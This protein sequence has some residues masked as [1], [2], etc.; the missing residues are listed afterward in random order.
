[1]CLKLPLLVLVALALPLVGYCQWN[2]QTS[3]T[4]FTINDIHYINE[5][6]GFLGTNSAIYKTMDRGASW[7]S[8]TYPAGIDGQILRNAY[9]NDILFLDQTNGLMTGG[10]YYGTYDMV[11]KTSDGGNSWQ[12]VYS[13]PMTGT[14][15]PPLM[16][17][18]FVDSNV[19]FIAGGG[20]K[21][22]K[23]Y[24]KGQTW[25]QIAS[26]TTKDLE[27]VFFVD[28]QNGFIAGNKVLLK[29]T[30]GGTSW[31]ATSLLAFH[32]K[33]L[34]FFTS[35]T[36]VAST[37][38]G[39]IL[40]TADGG[41]TWT[42]HPLNFEKSLTKM[43]FQGLTGYVGVFNGENKKLILKTTDGGETWE[44]QLIN[45]TY[46]NPMVLAMTP[47]GT[48]W[49]GG[50]YGKLFS[51][52]NGGGP[53][54]PIAAFTTSSNVFCQNIS[55]TFINKGSDKYTYEWRVD[56][57]VKST[58]HNF[59]TSFSPGNHTVELKAI[60]G[61]FSDKSEIS[62]FTEY[63]VGFSAPPE[64]VFD[65]G[66]CQG[67]ST[68]IVVKN[69][70]WA[71][72]KLMQGNV[73]L[74]TDEYPE[75]RFQTPLLQTTTTFKVVVSRSNSCETAT[76]ES[77]A[78]ITVHEDL[79]AGSN[80][81]AVQKYFCNEGQA[82]IKVTA[83]KAG[84]NYSLY[85]N[86]TLVN[87]TSG[88]GDNIVLQG[89]VIRD[90]TQFTVKA[91]VA[92]GVCTREFG[93]LIQVDVEQVKADFSLSATNAALN[94]PVNIYNLSSGATNF[95]W[96]F[97]GATTPSFTGASPSP[98]SFTHTGTLQPVLHASSNSGCTDVVT[99]NIHV[100]DNTLLKQSCWATGI[101]LTAERDGHGYEFF[102]NSSAIAPNGDILITGSFSGIAEFDSKVGPDLV[103]PNQ[104][105][106]TNFLARYSPTGVL[107]W[108]F[109]TSRYEI[110]NSASPVG[111][112]VAV[113]DDGSIYLLTSYGSFNPTFYSANGVATNPYEG[114]FV[115]S[116]NQHYLIKYSP[117]GML[118][119]IRSEKQITGETSADMFIDM[120]LDAS[121][122]IFIV[123]DHVYKISSSGDVLM[124]VKVFDSPVHNQ[125]A[126]FALSPDG[127]WYCINKRTTPILIRRYSSTGNAEWE[128]TISTVSYYGVVADRQNNLI[129]T[130][131]AYGA[132]NSRFTSNGEADRVLDPRSFFMVKYS[133]LGKISWLN[134]ALTNAAFRPGDLSADESGNISFTTAVA[135]TGQGMLQSQDG[136]H[137]NFSVPS[138]PYLISYDQNGSITY[139]K[140]IFEDVVA[141]YITKVTSKAGRSIVIG[142]VFSSEM[143]VSINN[144]ALYSAYP[145]TLFLAAFDISCAA[146]S[147]NVLSGSLEDPNVLFCAGSTVKLN[148]EVSA[149]TQLQPGNVIKVLLSNSDGNFNYGVRTIGTLTSIASQGIIQALLPGD[150]ASGNNY[151]LKLWATNPQLIS[152][153]LPYQLSIKSSLNLDFTYSSTADLVLNFKSSTTEVIDAR[154]TIEGNTIQELSPTYKF[155]TTGLFNVCLKAKN[156]C[157]VEETVCHD[158]VV[159]CAP[160][161]TDFTYSVTG[162]T[163]TFTG[164][165]NPSNALHW[166]FGD[167]AT[168]TNLNVQHTYSTY[169]EKG[170]CLRS[171]TECNQ[172]IACKS[173]TLTCSQGP[174]SFGSSSVDR[175]VQFSNTSPSTYTAF[176]WDFG[177]GTSS[178]DKNPTHLYD[179]PGTYTVILS[180]QGECRLQTLAKSVT[181]TCTSPTASPAGNAVQT[182]CPGATVANLSAIGTSVKWYATPTGGA[183]LSS[184][185]PLTN[186][187][188]YYASQTIGGCQST[189]RLDVN[190]SI[191]NT[192]SPAGNAVQTFC[193][194]ATVANLSVT[195]TS[196]KWYATPTGG[197]VLSLS[198]PLTNSKHY[199]ASQTI[200]G[201]ESTSRLDVNVSITNTASPAGNAVQTF[202]AGATVANLSAT[203]T[204]VKWYATPTGGA[205]L[206]S[207]TP[208]T[209]GTHYYASQTIGSCESSVRLD[210]S[211]SLTTTDP[212][213][214]NSTQTFC[215][216]ATISNLVVNG[217]FIKWYSALVGGSAL[218]SSTP[219]TNN[220]YYASQTINGCESLVR[221]KITAVENCPIDKTA[222]TIISTF[223]VNRTAD[224]DPSS[225]LTIHFSEP[226]VLGIPSKLRVRYFVN[227]FN[228]FQDITLSNSNTS[229]EGEIVTIQ[230]ETNLPDG[231]TVSILIDAG[232]FKDVNNNLFG[233]ITSLNTWTFSTRPTPDVIAP[234]LTSFVPAAGSTVAAP[235]S[236]V[237]NF[238]EYIKVQGG[239][240]TIVT[241][242]N[243]TPVMNVDLDGFNTTV[244][245]GK[246]TITLP[247]LL[248][249]N[250]KFYVW[251]SSDAITD[252]SGNKFEGIKDSHW[253]FSTLAL[254]TG[255][256]DKDKPDGSDLQ[257][258][259][260]GNYVRVIVK[261]PQIYI[262]M[263]SD[264]L[265]RT[266]EFERTN[267]GNEIIIH[268]CTDLLIIHGQN[269]NNPIM[270]KVAMSSR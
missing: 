7:T 52:K 84:V 242:A 77:N 38:E 29:T 100:Y 121:G 257:F 176:N 97:Y 178:T 68:S 116:A 18:A 108:A 59:Q 110:E 56:G 143:P 34:H 162:K 238:N 145:N 76:T 265:G 78:T 172:G 10:G 149:P 215:K 104:T 58:G 140:K 16:S 3:P 48:V 63:A 81:S 253:Q 47:G 25:T 22:L 114:V 60:N 204:S 174:L 133:S 171:T 102:K 90:T 126:D 134:T 2:A 86:G 136:N 190:V 123:N 205:V 218:P 99:K 249:Y 109:N 112:Y 141:N 252:V 113:D 168:A 197:A 118:Q 24:D 42:E 241:Q 147:Q 13:L 139:T 14:V 186:S 91:K 137:F 194:G 94:E 177:D 260:E 196:V 125:Y 209:N 43:V 87:S 36:G 170:V 73:V 188:H 158:V 44:H 224:V 263:I 246:L 151:R 105:R 179:E 217:T 93:G 54:Y 254:I 266:I 152:S 66:I 71:Q 80:A 250:E 207:S 128:N 65:D 120:E 240:I 164:V 199:Y 69:P 8:P 119:W 264:V 46:F 62:F 150:I 127:S 135:S 4:S 96:T 185:T 37:W 173:I 67:M 208:L 268:Q 230:S 117:D 175:S 212:P 228:T 26:P 122:N 106:V 165:T 131:S 41:T 233:G 15:R 23:T 82:A 146:V 184:S 21:I 6:T 193:P 107:K 88:N 203:G 195:G 11:A 28:T 200:G 239:S 236:L 232:A 229:I 79:W 55:Y 159:T 74:A 256:E 214:G 156:E 144:D 27:K 20:G 129:L 138:C 181:I 180:S 95:Q 155:A 17:I 247:E 234:L 267:N 30:D 85:T 31:Q 210:V 35:T 243:R 213:T 183:V 153:T 89:P 227:G 182:F 72:Y 226:V 206:S 219:L 12:L 98:V 269:G 222:P 192:A 167:G 248:P 270:W 157:N 40:R 19:G 231:M 216:G 51:T 201:C 70:E 160:V 92:N 163:I 223:P 189:S 220:T 83:S 221:L 130:G 169:G 202:C 57:V 64:L 115:N 191:T 111:S 166:D 103:I 244:D 262:K 154:W 1:M 39:K 49:A 225:Q 258:I 198:T 75:I 187:T 101:G 33:D 259:T 148:Y 5:N 61:A 142:S 211:A 235:T 245:K 251:V 45:G 32:I 9:V 124:K 132:G 50:S 255:L 161:P 53:A 237:M 261:N